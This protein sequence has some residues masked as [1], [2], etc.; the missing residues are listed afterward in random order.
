MSMPPTGYWILVCNPVKWAF[1][2]FVLEHLSRSETDAWG[3]RPSDALGFAPGQLALVR[4]GNDMRSKF[5]LEG[6][7]RL[8]A[9]IYA[10]CEVTSKPF[11]SRGAGA[12]FGFPGSEQ[13]VVGP[14]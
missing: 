2:K 5:Q 4:V 8:V 9:G 7:P 10:L 3:V 14:T 1:D 12:A 13:R 6:R 11:F